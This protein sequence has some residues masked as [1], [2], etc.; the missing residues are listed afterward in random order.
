LDNVH[1]D[2]RTKDALVDAV[3]EAH[4][5]GIQATIA[6]LG[7]HR[8][9]RQRLKPLIRRFAAEAEVIAQYRSPHGT[10]CSDLEKTEKP[11]CWVGL[12]V[13]PPEEP[14]DRTTGA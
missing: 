5:Q 7:G 11:A 14:I 3:V 1:Y 2:F 9:V 4:V 13:A 12:R 10:S 8:T 6:A